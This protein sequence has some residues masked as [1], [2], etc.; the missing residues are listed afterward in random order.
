MKRKIYL[1]ERQLHKIISESVKKVLRE[2]VGSG[3]TNHNSQVSQNSIDDDYEYEGELHAQYNDGYVV[4]KDGK[5]NVENDNEELVF[6]FWFDDLGPGNTA[7]DEMLIGLV[8]GKKFLL[9]WV[10]GEY[11]EM[12]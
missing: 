6:P 11:K 5:Y 12:R 3:W 9:N 8:K 7:K 4:T 2:S 1:N 10:T